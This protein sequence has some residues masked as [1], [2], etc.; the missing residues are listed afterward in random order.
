MVVDRDV[1]Q[2]PDNHPPVWGSSRQFGID[3]LELANVK[4]VFKI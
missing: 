2:P 4:I 1:A 3:F